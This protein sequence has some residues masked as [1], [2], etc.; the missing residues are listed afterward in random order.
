MIFGV[1]NSGKGQLG[2]SSMLWIEV[3]SWYSA[4]FIGR[5]ST[6]RMALLTLHSLVENGWKAGLS[7]N[8]QPKC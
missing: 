8:C 3:T 5:P 6:S 4:D 7:W 2:D 1:D